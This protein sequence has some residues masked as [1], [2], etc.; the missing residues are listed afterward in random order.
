MKKVFCFVVALIILLFVCACDQNN[1][2]ITESGNSTTDVSGATESTTEVA[3]TNIPGSD[4]TDSTI[5]APT[6]K[7]ILQPTTTY[8]KSGTTTKPSP[9]TTPEQ[10][11]NDSN[12]I[13]DNNGIAYI[14][15]EGYLWV[16]SYGTCTQK[17]ITIPTLVN[18]KSVIGV[19]SCAFTANSIIESVTFSE[20][21]T[22]IKEG[23][24]LACSRLKTV[25]F[26][27]TLKTLEMNAFSD[28]PITSMTLPSGLEYIGRAAFKSLQMKQ[29][30]LPKSVR[31]IEHGA[32]SKS[33]LEE[34]TIPGNVTLGASVFSKCSNLTTVILQEGIT[35]IPSGTFD[36][37]SSLT[38]LN[39]PS[40][41]VSIGSN[42]FYGC[43]K[44][45]ISQLTLKNNPSFDA[46]YNL[47][48]E[49]V[50]VYVNLSQRSFNSA[51]IQKLTIHE[52]VT[53]IGKEVFMHASIGSITLPSTLS[54]VNSNAFY[55]SKID[56]VVFTRA[57]SL[58]YAAFRNSTIQEITLVVGSTFD[59]YVFSDCAQLGTIRFVGTMK[60][61]REM[62]QISYGLSSLE[63]EDF[64]KIT[65]ICSDG[66][67][68]PQ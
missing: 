26:P 2:P 56:K 30:T 42:A 3:S 6:A 64:N 25:N 23:A 5:T 52:G 20:G 36:Y 65:I 46:F 54:E 63:Y 9:T 44:L 22:T 11:Q 1:T 53:S 32:F 7:P 28:C 24:F 19:D 33:A 15:S 66:T 31:T 62:L 68:A 8:I 21:I 18:G 67:I 47:K 50:D 57:V 55:G 12:K 58:G 13:Y 59:S 49:N 61:W 37:C 45:T 10:F 60:Q 34:I 29:L 51:K 39:I 38:T 16:S 48:I 27:S 17:D 40:L 43:S 41:V 35:A 4:S 14:L